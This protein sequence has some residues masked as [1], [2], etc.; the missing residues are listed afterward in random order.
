MDISTLQSVISIL[1][2]GITWLI[3][4][5]LRTS[6]D[7]LQ[8]SIDELKTEIHD[9]YREFKKISDRVTKGEVVIKN[10]TEKIEKLEKQFTDFCKDCHCVRNDADAKNKQA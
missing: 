1:V 9:H 3:V 10:N 8:K 6:I 2:L 4:Q 7:G 5:P